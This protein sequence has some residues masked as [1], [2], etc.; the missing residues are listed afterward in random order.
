MATATE[1]QVHVRDKIYIGGEWV[2]S[3][4]SGVLEVVNSATE[5]VMGSIPEGTPDD[6]DRGVAAARAA[7]DTWSQTSVEERAEWMERI[8]GALG[9]R[10]DEIAALIAQEV[11]MPLKL[12]SMIQAGLPTM[13]FGS[14]P[15]VMAEMA[16]EEEVGN[17]L[18]VR[19]PVGVV[20]AITPWNYPLHQIAAKVAPAWPRAAQWCSSPL[21]SL[22]STRFSWPTCSTSWSCRPACSTWSAASGPWSARRCRVTPTWT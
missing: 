5:E 14:M 10:M 22:R 3:G 17:S 13:S 11:G 7:F 18:I 6:V 12:S 9:A 4:G 16:W 1:Q 20:G 19:E 8:A 15:Q 21:R 2:A